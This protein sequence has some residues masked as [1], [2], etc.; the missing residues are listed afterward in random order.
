[1]WYS[2]GLFERMEA[3]Y[4][5]RYS[6]KLAGAELC[7]PCLLPWRAGRNVQRVTKQKAFT[8]NSCHP[9]ALQEAQAERK[10]EAETWSCCKERLAVAVWSIGVYVGE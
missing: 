4:I 10:R 5:V 8:V 7:F 1:M 3:A 6:R 2:N 9:V